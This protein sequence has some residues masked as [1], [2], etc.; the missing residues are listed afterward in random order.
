MP[1]GASDGRRQAAAPHDRYR[2]IPASQ[3]SHDTGQV[4]S[5]TRNLAVHGC[6]VSPLVLVLIPFFVAADPRRAGRELLRERRL[7]RHAAGLHAGELYRRASPQALTWR[8][9]L[10]TV[11]FAVLT[12][13][14]TL[15]H[16]LLV[17][18][19]LVFHV[20]N[21]LLAI[22]LFLL[23]TV[24][25]WTSNIIRM[26]SWIPLLGQ[27]RADQL[28]AARHRRRSS[29]RSIPALLRTSRSSS[30]MSTSSR[31]S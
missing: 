13:S 5:A 26:I 18:Y 12:W 4:M 3:A 20:R 24:P 17:A 16:R 14:F 10:T 8:L 23:C 21:L 30:P 31:S 19:F 29:S 22:G 1:A 11:K 15:M 28:G 27:G 2:Q 7:R 9:Y 25:F 6:Y